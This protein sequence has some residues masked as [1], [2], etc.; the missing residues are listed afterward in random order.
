M[1]IIVDHSPPGFLGG[2]AV[3][4]GQEDAR[5]Q[6]MLEALEMAEEQRRQR[7]LDLRM[8]DR[9][10]ELERFRVE[11]Q[12]RRATERANSD[13]YRG[14]LGGGGAGIMPGEWNW[15]GGPQQPQ[16]TAGPRPSQIG[17][18]MPVDVETGAALPRAAPQQPM[19]G[20][21]AASGGF[22]IPEGVSADALEPFAKEVFQQRMTRDRERQG[23]QMLMQRAG[24]A[25][26]Q[27]RLSPRMIQALQNAPTLE[28]GQKMFMEAEQRG[29]QAEALAPYIDELV[30]DEQNP[31]PR[32]DVA[33]RV[34]AFKT[35]QITAAQLLNDLEQLQKFQLEAKADAFEKHERAQAEAAWMAEMEAS[36]YLSPEQKGLARLRATA[37]KSIPFDVQEKGEGKPFDLSS[38]V[39]DHPAV[40]AAKAELEAAQEN[41]KAADD[42]GGK[43]AAAREL[44]GAAQNYRQAVTDATNEIIHGQRG[45]A[46]QP[47]APTPV[48][49]EVRRSLYEQAK[50]AAKASAGRD[51]TPAEIQRAFA[52]LWQ[53]YQRGQK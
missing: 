16:I 41:L 47:A 50:T 11:Q 20:Q 1:P 49:D 5:Q 6:A 4:M 53:N 18:A 31:L 33:V 21:P 17:G 24:M 10:Q 14:V 29:I 45:G 46:A 8:E 51:P 30:N 38:A 48:P 7:E 37:P 28:A 40:I 26:Q 39:A 32:R 25:A 34:E 2:A 44:Q 22:Q 13:F 35:G 36:P 9:R 52:V 43:K 3:R 27:G 42:A 19:Y 15:L 23:R 12:E